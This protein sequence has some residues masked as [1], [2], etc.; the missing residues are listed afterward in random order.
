MRTKIFLEHLQHHSKLLSL[1]FLHIML[2]F[3][4][5]WFFVWPPQNFKQNSLLINPKVVSNWPTPPPS[6]V[7]PVAGSLG[8]K[9]LK[10]SQSFKDMASKIFLRNLYELSNLLSYGFCN[11]SISFWQNQIFLQHCLLFT[12]YQSQSGLKVANPAPLLCKSCSR[13]VGFEIFKNK[14]EFW[15]YGSQNFFA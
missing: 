9:F 10:L 11:I 3:E 12:S 4:E 1:G 2:R 14:L 6:C 15:R 7:N 5:N 8:L 13:G